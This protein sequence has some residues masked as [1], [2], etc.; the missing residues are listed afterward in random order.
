M[1]RFF[2]YFKVKIE[3]EIH[4]MFLSRKKS[5]DPVLHQNQQKI[6]VLFTSQQKYT[7]TTAK[8]Y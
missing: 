6:H 7:S 3:R 5:C 1:H 8:V 4:V 2:V